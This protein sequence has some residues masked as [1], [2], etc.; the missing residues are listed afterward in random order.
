M[1][2][3]C[4]CFFVIFASIILLGCKGD[5]FSMQGL[6]QNSVDSVLIYPRFIG[7]DFF[8]D[9]LVKD[10]RISK[11]VSGGKFEY[12]G[13]VA[14]PHP[15]RVVSPTL[16]ASEI[17][18][19]DKGQTTFEIDF[20]KQQKIKIKKSSESQ[21]EY[22]S[23]KK[24][25]LHNVGSDTNLSIQRDSILVEY[26]GENPDS[27]VS[28]WLL[29]EDLCVSGYN[30][31]Q[32]ASL[33]LFSG[34]VK[35]SLAYTSFKRRLKFLESKSF[36]GISLALKDTELKS[37]QIKFENLIPKY[38]LVDFWFSGC[39]PCLRI[40][41]SYLPIYT[42]YK[43]SGFEIVAISVDRSSEQQ[44]WLKSISDNGFVWLNFL[45][46]NGTESRKLNVSTFPSNF[47]VDR[48]GNIVASNIS[49][50]ELEKFLQKNL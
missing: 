49:S 33:K 47:L 34:E 23:L 4:R 20:L 25:F 24:K 32:S 18:F 27:Y 48:S 8:S 46:E 21:E 39:A 31:Y 40:M 12:S 1:K 15:F 6:V 19:V 7:A 38:T 14:Y 13:K 5:R 28:L 9:S 2:Q 29:I 42:K 50:S 26:I 22:A 36:S 45:D 3:C 16:G 10:M 41:P 11:K 37:K 17:F 30:P 35:S 43:S 44:K